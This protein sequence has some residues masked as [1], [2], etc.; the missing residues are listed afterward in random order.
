MNV[1]WCEEQKPQP[2]SRVSEEGGDGKW[3]AQLLVCPLD[4]TSSAV[5]SEGECGVGQ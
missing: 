1:A 4:V 3:T 5:A 2:S